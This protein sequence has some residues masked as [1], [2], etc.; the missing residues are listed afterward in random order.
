MQHCK[1]ANLQNIPQCK[2]AKYEKLQK[3]V[4]S[5]E[6]KNNFEVNL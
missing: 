3:E 5:E 1:I 2:I 6:F 4:N